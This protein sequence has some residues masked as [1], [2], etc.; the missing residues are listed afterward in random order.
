MRTTAAPRATCASLLERTEGRARSTGWCSI[1]ATTAAA[2]CRRRPPSPACSSITARWC[3]CGTPPAGSRCSMIRS[4]RATMTARSRC[5]SIA[6]APRLRRSS[7]A[8]SRTI[9]AASSSASA[10]SARARCRTSCRSIA[11]RRSPVN[12]QLTVTIGKFYRIT[13]E[14]TQHRG[15]EPDVALP[16]PIDMKEVGESALDSALPWDRIAGVPF[17][18]EGPASSTPIPALV[19]RR[20]HARAARCGLPLAGRATSPPSTPSASRRRCRST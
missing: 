11:G 20:G 16:S 14:S 13:G 7:P 12:G 17:H 15:V 6:S 9:T 4:P 8:P 3:S 5:W 18:T 1:C 2:I 19:E 10:P